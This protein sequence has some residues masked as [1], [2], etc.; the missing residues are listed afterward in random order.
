MPTVLI[1]A[2]LLGYG[3]LLLELT[4]LHVPSV[5]SSRAIWARPNDLE[6]AYSPT[7]RRVFGFSPSLKLLLFVV[8]LLVTYGVYLYPLVTL[9]GSRDPLGDHLFAP[10]SLSDAFAALLIVAG[11]GVALATVLTIR[12]E[13]R[14]APEEHVLHTDGPFRH[15]RNPGLVGMYLFVAG[16]WLAGPSLA[17]A[18]GIVVYLLHMDFKVRMEEDFLQNRFREV[19][20]AY[21][22]RT[23]RYWP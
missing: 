2:I 20:S 13:G 18:V 14:R 16:L 7:Y 11:R 12:G 10:S 21:R 23:S 9:W 6:A 19:Y 17:M 4:V 5:A 1:A 8:P 3:S 22:G 15:S